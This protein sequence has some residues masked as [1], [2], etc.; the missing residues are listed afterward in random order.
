MHV[1]N[2]YQQRPDSTTIVPYAE[3]VYREATVG[4]RFNPWPLVAAIY[5]AACWVALFIAIAVIV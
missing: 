1:S 3:A 5:C 4:E 2:N